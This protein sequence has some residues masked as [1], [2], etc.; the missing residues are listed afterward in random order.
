MNRRE[1][2]LK[3]ATVFI[4]LMICLI[5]SGCDSGKDKNTNDEINKT[6]GYCLVTTNDNYIIVIPDYGPVVMTDKSENGDLFDGLQTGDKIEVS[7]AFIN[8]SY[9]GQANTSYCK[10]ISRGSF[11]DIPQDIYERL[12]EL[13]WIAK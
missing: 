12:E 8:E 7:F 9:P 13:G 11:E 1:I 5:L 2:S 10:I 3:K 4:V 6:I